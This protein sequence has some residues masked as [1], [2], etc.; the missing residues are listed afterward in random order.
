MLSRSFNDMYRMS[1]SA[2]PSL[3]NKAPMAAGV[4]F[5]GPIDGAM[6]DLVRRLGRIHVVQGSR[7]YSIF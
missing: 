7:V 3:G 2:S 5:D 1:A 6:I 4:A